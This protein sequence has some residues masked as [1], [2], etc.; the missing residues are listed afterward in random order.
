MTVS[1]QG[2]RRLLLAMLPLVPVLVL[3]CAAP[4]AAAPAE[5]R[6]AAEVAARLTQAPV[7]RGKFEQRRYLSGFDKP[8]VSR[9][10]FVV[11]R[12]HGMVWTTR[13]PLVSTLVVSA[14]GLV[15]RGADG[16]VQQRIGATVQ[17]G[18]GMMAESVL[19][20]MRGDMAGLSHAFEIDGTLVGARGW[21]VALV[22]R[23]ARLRQALSRIALSG[24]QHVRA[25]TVGET[26][27]DRTEVRLYELSTAEALSADEERGF[28]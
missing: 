3:P 23:D 25:L 17:P 28:D 4:V 26:G 27:G 21:K 15:V 16:A 6:L 14:D 1:L 8:L 20:V 24:D 19:A 11:S 2:R 13:A 22:P 5:G 10:D 12:A 9:G 7:V 18:V